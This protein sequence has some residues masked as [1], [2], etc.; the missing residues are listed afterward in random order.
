MIPGFG[1]LGGS[2]T[3]AGS[4]SSFGVASPSPAG[5]VA[6]TGDPHLQNIHGERF[7]LMRPGKHVLIHIPRG[8]RVEK[9][10]LRVEAEAS[11][12]GG[13]CADMYFQGLNITG[14]W[15]EAKQIGGIRFHA[16]DVGDGDLNWDKF[17]KV[18]LKVVHGHTRKGT[19]YLNLYVRHL[20]HAGY[21]V[22]G[23]LGEDD[24]EEAAMPSPAC[25]QRLS[26]IQGAL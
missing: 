2:A 12:L 10:L 7:D 25:A 22:G 5:A 26:L 1:G 23:L 18:E 16:Q 6:A 15:A 24:H 20:G 17:G 14:A 21:T 4:T 13:S 19:Q 3:S 9:A 11:R 8:E